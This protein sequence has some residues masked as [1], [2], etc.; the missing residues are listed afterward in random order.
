MKPPVG[1]ARPGPVTSGRPGRQHG[2]V[3]EKTLTVRL[4]ESEHRA[5][6]LYA[7][8]QG[9]SMDA[10][11]LELIRA[12]LTK[13]APAAESRSRQEREEF[14]AGLLARFGIDPTS[15]EHQAAAAR[16]QASIRYSHSPRPADRPANGEP[17]D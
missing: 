15:P 17:R 10:A 7:V 14:V 2:G 12:E 13:A 4:S 8:R 16:A 9:R 6:R 5:L 3:T 11:V 1:P